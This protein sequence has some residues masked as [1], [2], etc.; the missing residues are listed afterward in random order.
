M[1]AVTK[2][3]TKIFSCKAEVYAKAR[4]GYAKTAV[5]YL[6]TIGLNKNSIVADIG[7]GTGIFSKYLLD[8]GTETYCVEPNAEMRAKAEQNLSSYPNFHSIDASAENTTLNDASMDFITVAQAFHWFDTQAFK[9]ESLRILKPNGKAVLL[10]NNGSPNECSR[11]C[12]DLFQRFNPSFQESN[13]GH[14]K[15]FEN[16]DF[17]FKNY[18]MKTFDNALSYD[19]E[20]FIASSLS[21]SRALSSKD[22]N[23]DE[24][25][26]GLEQIFDKYQQDGKISSP[27]ET[28]LYI[29]E[30]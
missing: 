22:K 23:F 30:I 9:K 25:V 17:Y 18:E 3:N 6:L 20:L 7:S 2:D 26:K 1:N 13:E 29:G 24:Y 10:W 8:I 27:T 12:E 11:E 4:P 14:K 28:A 19:K 21:T 5:D 15:L 16:I